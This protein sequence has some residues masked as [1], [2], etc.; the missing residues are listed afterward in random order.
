MDNTGT[1]GGHAV[2]VEG[3]PRVVGTAANAAIEFNGR[4]DGLVVDAN[5]LVGLRAF[6]MEVEFRP[7]ADAGADQA[8]QRFVHVE[9]SDTGNRALVELRDAGRRALGARYLPALRRRR[10]DAS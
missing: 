4:T 1:I 9:E 7:A 6:T 3:A 10:R 8:E 5:P 2:S